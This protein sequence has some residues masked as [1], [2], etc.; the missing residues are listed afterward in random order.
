MLHSPQVCNHVVRLLP[1]GNDAAVLRGDALNIQRLNYVQRVIERNLGRHDAFVKLIDP[2]DWAFLSGVRADLLRGALIA[3]QIQLDKE[4]PVCVVAAKQ[5]AGKQRLRLFVKRYK[6]AR[7]MA[8]RRRVKGQAAS[9][10]K[11]ILVF[12]YAKIGLSTV[13]RTD[14]I[15][16]GIS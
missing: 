8:E 16:Y 9:R 3:V 12:E 7:R 5:V 10:F 14:F 6:T 4:V 15:R 1:R 11:D 2:V 13:S